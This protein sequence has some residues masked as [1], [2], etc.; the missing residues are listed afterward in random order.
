[1]SWLWLKG[2]PITIYQADIYAIK[3]SINQM[4]TSKDLKINQ[5]NTFDLHSY[6]LLKLENMEKKVMKVNMDFIVVDHLVVERKNEM[7][8]S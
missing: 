2:G 1:M 7:E 4:D 3:Q 6:Y 8:G 5:S